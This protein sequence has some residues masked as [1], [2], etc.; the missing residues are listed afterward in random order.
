ML[1]HTAPEQTQQ[2]HGRFVFLSPFGIAGPQTREPLQ[3]SRLHCSRTNTA[4]TWSLCFAFSSCHA[5][6]TKKENL[7]DAEG[8]TAPEQTQQQ[9]GH[10]AVLSPLGI[11]GPTAPE[12]MQQQHGHFAVLSP[13][14]IAGHQAR[15]PG[16]DRGPHCS[17]TKTAIK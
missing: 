10:F 6:A 17:R 4:A 14:G 9:H 16:Q 13:L 1:S 2:Q 15:E 8:C 7:D 5:M 11:A 12:Q 3:G